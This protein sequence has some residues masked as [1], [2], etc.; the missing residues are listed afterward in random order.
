MYSYGIRNP[1]IENEKSILNYL[2]DN[3]LDL[4]NNF[5]LKDTAALYSFMKSGVG[6]PE[7]LFYDKNGFLMRYK[8]DKKC[9]GQ[10]D[11]LISFLDPKHIIGVDSS[12][13]V[14]KYLDQVRTLDG[15]EVNVSEFKEKDYILIIY[16]AKW[17]GK[18]NKN[19]IVD[20]ENSLTK[21]NNLKIKTIKLSTDYMG[22]WQIKK[23]DMFKI[24]SHTTKTQAIKRH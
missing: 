13:N 18:M 7:I 1:K 2:K 20:W 19:K 6:A 17:M 14:Y 11:S 16:W 8:D 9:N 23:N 24:Y 15:K 10:N 5:V 4:D 21:R 22:F 12:S 3:N